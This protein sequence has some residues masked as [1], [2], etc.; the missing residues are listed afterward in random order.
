MRWHFGLDIRE[1]GPA[2]LLGL[3]VCTERDI[4]KLCRNLLGL[5]VSLLA[6]LSLH[7]ERERGG[8][9]ERVGPGCGR[10][11]KFITYT[12]SYFT[13]LEKHTCHV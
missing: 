4:F 10:Y 12:H 5:F 8:G 13:L 9:A 2:N 7:K 6:A 3:F 11:T 1:R